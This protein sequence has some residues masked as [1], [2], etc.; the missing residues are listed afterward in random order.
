MST[1]SISGTQSAAS[2][3]SAASSATNTT[4]NALDKDAFLKL[5]VTQLQNQDPM[6][7]MEDKEFISQMAQFS[8]L[9]QMQ[10]MNA[11]F[12][13]MAQT[14]SSGFDS[15]TKSSST[16]QSLSLIGKKIDYIDPNDSTKTLSGTVD[17]V[18]F[19]SGV[20]SLEIG[21]TKVDMSTVMNVY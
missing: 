17:K 20:P 3:A 2:T 18:T 15:M 4:S 7:P 16:T 10:Q 14:S 1:D 11:G 8:S 21:N 12:T 13:T 9:E 6:Q 19:S 5:L